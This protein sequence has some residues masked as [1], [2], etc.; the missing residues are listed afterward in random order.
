MIHDKIDISKMI[1]KVADRTIAELT[2]TSGIA[3]R[4]PSLMQIF[5]VSIVESGIRYQWKELKKEYTL[6]DEMFYDICDWCVT[7]MFEDYVADK[8]I[9]VAGHRK[10]DEARIVYEHLEFEKKEL[11]LALDLT[12]MKQWNSGYIKVL[13]LGREA[14]VARPSPMTEF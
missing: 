10:F 13:V 5:P 11:F 8:G 2:N 12:G 14:L 6:K 4:P 3:K 7:Q 9:R 1:R